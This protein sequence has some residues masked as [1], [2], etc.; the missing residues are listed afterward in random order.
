MRNQENC[1]DIILLMILGAS[2]IVGSY[3]VIIL[4]TNINLVDFKEIRDAPDR[5][6][7]GNFRLLP[8]LGKKSASK[9]Q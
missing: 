5:K 7:M 2:K 6:V 3:S 1:S 8:I 4:P 9:V